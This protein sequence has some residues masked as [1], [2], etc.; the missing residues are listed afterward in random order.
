[1]SMKSIALIIDILLFLMICFH[2][3]DIKLILMTLFIF[4]FGLGMV[5][6]YCYGCWLDDIDE[7]V[8]GKIK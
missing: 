6:I 4:P 3:R 7:R 2:M 8:W 5:A 1:M